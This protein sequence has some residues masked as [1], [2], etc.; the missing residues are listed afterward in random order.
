MLDGTTTNWV[1]VPGSPYD[2]VPELR[3]MRQHVNWEI[4]HCP[5]PRRTGQV[6]IEHANTDIYT[7]WNIATHHMGH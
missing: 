2:C 3:I 1:C 5:T 4:K 6:G 7:I